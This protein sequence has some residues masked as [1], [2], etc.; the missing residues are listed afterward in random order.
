MIS[1]ISL[2]T[3]T[4][5]PCQNGI[6]WTGD[7]CVPKSYLISINW[8]TVFLLELAFSAWA[9]CALWLQ[10]TMTVQIFV[11][12][13]VFAWEEI[14]CRTEFRIRYVTCKIA[15]GWDDVAH[16]WIKRLCVTKDTIKRLTHKKG[17][18][19]QNIPSIRQ[20]VYS[21]PVKSMIL[22]FGRKTC[23]F[24]F[25]VFLAHAHSLIIWSEASEAFKSGLWLWV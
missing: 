19:F 20:N 5:H 13:F 10:S 7:V 2:L 11:T 15:V 25:I 17:K 24:I 4:N 12:R 21:L 14:R 6:S 23:F 1:I 16:Q 3:Q 22:Y 8:K 9:G 18:H